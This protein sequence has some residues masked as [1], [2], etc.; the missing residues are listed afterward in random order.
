MTGSEKTAHFAHHFK[1]ELLVFQGRVALAKAI[2]CG[3]FFVMK[4]TCYGVLAISV[5]L[6]LSTVFKLKFEKKLISSSVF[7]FSIILTTYSTYVI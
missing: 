5:H 1:I 6:F 4:V 7:Q 3:N 2:I